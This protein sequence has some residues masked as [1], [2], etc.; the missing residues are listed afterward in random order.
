MYKKHETNWFFGTQKAIVKNVIK[1]FFLLVSPIFVQ[2][3]KTID[4]N[5]PFT[6]KMA[7]FLKN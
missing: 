6:K 5:K 3:L 7:K 1:S 4:Q 2:Y